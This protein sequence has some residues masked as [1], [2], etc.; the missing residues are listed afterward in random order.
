MLVGAG[1]LMR[2]FERLLREDPGFTEL[3]STTFNLQVPSSSYE[4]WTEVSDFYARLLGRT[5]EVEGVRGAAV[6]AFLPLDPGWPI[7][8]AV[9][10]RAP[11]PDGEEPKVQYHSVSPGYFRLIGIPLLRGRDVSDRDLA[12]GPGVVVVN[13]AARRR[14][15]PDEDPIGARVLTEARQFGPLGRVMPESLELEVVGLVADVKNASLQN[16]AE[17]AF[18]FSFRQFAYRSM[19]VVVRAEA[20]DGA[21]PAKLR[22][23]VW[24]LDAD[25]PVSAMRPLEADLEEAVASER[26]VLVALGA[27][28]LLALALAAVGTY[29]VLSCA[30]GERRREIAIRMALGAR[31]ATVKHALLGRALVLASAGVVLG[32]ATAWLLGSYLQSF[33]FGV[34]AHDPLAFG[35][36]ALVLIATAL[37]ASYL[38]AR[39]ASR[40]DPWSTLRAE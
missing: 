37:A 18:Y 20:E 34:S 10:G 29:G 15:W 38:P 12:E 26:F 1:L 19:N 27:F 32:G 35:V 13:D 31:P 25:L 16:E 28:A 14:Y 40:A 24:S 2:S 36:S 6:T 7:P 5:G 21:L 9:K 17:P 33:L 39:R 22:E 8:F 30:A 11:V 23:A 3:R 4:D